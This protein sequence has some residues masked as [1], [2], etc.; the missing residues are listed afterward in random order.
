MDPFVVL[1]VGVVF[2]I[3]AI[4][5][6][7]VH[8]F[9]ALLVAAILVGILGR[10]DLPGADPVLPRAAQA[11]Q[12]T[13]REFGSLAGK[14]GIV[15]AMA[16]VIGHCLMQS[17]AADKITR[18]LLAVLGEK[19]ANY[20]LLGSGYV[21]SVP[22]FFDTV[23]FLLVPLARALRMRTG[24]HYVAY[25][26]AISAGGVITHSLVPPTP[27]PLIMV[28]SLGLDLGM[29][30]VGGFLLGLPVAVVAGIW[31]PRV[32]ERLSEIPLRDAPG[33]TE[34]ELREIVEK[35]EDELPGF[36]V[37]MAPVVL[38]VVLI[39]THSIFG[40]I[41]KVLLGSFAGSL[42]GVATG[43]GVSAV[44]SWWLALLAAE[45]I[46]DVTSVAGDKHFALGLGM[47]I[48]LWLLARQRGY[49]L[50]RLTESIEPALM[51]GATIIL[52]TCAGG[53]FGAMLKHLD[54]G[55]Q[56]VIQ[57][58]ASEGEGVYLLLLAWGIAATMK[59]AQGS[60]TVAM[61]TAAAILGELL[62]RG[63]DLPFHPIYVFASIAY[64]SMFVSWM[65][66]SGFW[67]VSKMS[68]LRQGEALR[69]W[70]LQLGTMGVL[71]LGEVL[72]LSRF[73][74]LG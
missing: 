26:M 66:D 42:Q 48:A 36:A 73:L 1:V 2:V 47:V 23:F 62:G 38:P 15:I 60:G 7:K 12:V 29:T 27:G 46:L 43:A 49:T 4:A 35:R 71:G 53:A 61:I 54:L 16:A 58:L 56:P 20:A 5:V 30:I 68:G 32:V 72:L 21:L 6:F 34:A 44:P 41:D 9:F 39:T 69:T 59:I 11:I 14:I 28:E 3:L 74:P 67:V 22:V 52:I 64:G 17:G 40:A 33:S 37:S 24:R 19:R 18:R 70:T 45:P 25:V 50:T 31:L 8:P 13:A 55:G 63:I 51:A 57:R 65:N 10:G